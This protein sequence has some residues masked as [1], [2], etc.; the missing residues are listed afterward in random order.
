MD[1]DAYVQKLK[2]QLDDWNVEAAK[3]EARARE[4]Q[5]TAKGEYDKQLAALNDR[6]E[7]ALYQMKLLQGA[8]TDAWRDVMSG[9]DK[10]WKELQDA[11]SRA[12]SHFDGK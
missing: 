10:A 1:R 2:Q 6:R 11:V 5:T 7:E 3:W 12:R 8:S 4:A 9:A